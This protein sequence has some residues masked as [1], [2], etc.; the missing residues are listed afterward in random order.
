MPRQLLN[1][2]FAL[3]FAVQYVLVNFFMPGEPLFV[4]F[5]CNA[6]IIS[7]VPLFHS[8]C[9]FFSCSFSFSFR[10]GN[11]HTDRL[12]IAEKLAYQRAMGF[13]K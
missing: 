8:T 11:W 9:F 1:V 7:F 6:M 12:T 13:D 10:S 4:L 3:F 5:F 2:F